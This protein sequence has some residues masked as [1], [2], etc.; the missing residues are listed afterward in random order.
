M[1][2]A[3]VT[4]AS[5][6]IGRE[7]VVRI[8]KKFELD[9]I[10][11]IA[12]RKERLEELKNL[13]KTKIKVL[14]LDLTD[15]NS[16]D[17]YARELET[18]KPNVKI[19]VNAGGFG[20]FGAFTDIPLA[21]QYGMIDLNCKALVGM[22]F[23]TLPYMSRGA[24]IIEMSSISAFQPV[25]YINVY[26]ASKSFVLSFSRSLGVELKSRGI[27]VTAVCPFWVKTE[28]FDR[29]VTDD[30]VK[31]YAR[32]LTAENVVKTALKDAEKGKAVSVC[33]F[34]NKCQALAAKLLP[35]SLVMKIWCRQ[36]GK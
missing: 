5:S 14:A 16:L 35:H 3:V 7:V 28:F 23:K 8:D 31:Y 4:G 15:E 27:T 26:A 10:W 22:T 19:L 34:A 1:N 11:V 33:G 21:E 2:I 24:T 6:G 29:A 9:E 18:A 12:R 32:F 20:K 25:P 17:T 13:T 30:T 36:Q